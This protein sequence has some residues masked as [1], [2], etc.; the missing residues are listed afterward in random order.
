MEAAARRGDLYSPSYPAAVGVELL[1]VK[2]VTQIVVNGKGAAAG[3][4]T[5]IRGILAFE[6]ATC[7]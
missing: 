5:G 2:L 4:V 3:H 1:H 6:G 7:R